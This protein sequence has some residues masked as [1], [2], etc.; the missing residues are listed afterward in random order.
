MLILLF[1]CL[2]PT[3]IPV[4]QVDQ[5]FET[6]QEHEGMNSL[7]TSPVNENAWDLYC[8]CNDNYTVREEDFAPLKN[9]TCES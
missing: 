6:Y 1:S 9:G 5:C 3:Y 2:L 4:C 7:K 8:Y